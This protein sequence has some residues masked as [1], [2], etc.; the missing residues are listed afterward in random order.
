MRRGSGVDHLVVDQLIVCRSPPRVW[1]ARPHP[2]RLDTRP[3]SIYCPSRKRRDT[4]AGPGGPALPGDA[5]PGATVSPCRPSGG[6]RSRPEFDGVRQCHGRS[7]SLRS[8]RLHLD[9]ACT[10]SRPQADLARGGA[11]KLSSAPLLHAVHLPIHL[12]F[13]LLGL[14]IEAA[15]CPIVAFKSGWCPWGGHGHTTKAHLHRD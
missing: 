15:S 5:S 9:V 1:P 6:R 12:P 10:P 2:S 13:H 14:R 4:P 7:S 8:G 3:P 11:S